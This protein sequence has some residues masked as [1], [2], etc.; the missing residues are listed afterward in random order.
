M[1]MTVYKKEALVIAFKLV[2]RSTRL[3]INLDGK[4]VRFTVRDELTTASAAISKS[5]GS[6]ITHDPDQAT[7]PGAG[8]LTLTTSDTDL[9]VSEYFWDLWV[10][11]EVYVAPSIFEVALSVRQP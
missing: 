8:D 7:N 3:G 5:T 4:V 2:N 11:D 6:G 9:D 1:R 10:D